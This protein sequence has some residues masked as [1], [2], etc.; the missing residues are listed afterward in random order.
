MDFVVME[1]ISGQ[2]L[3]QV[4]PRRGLPSD[5]WLDYALQMAGA[6]AAAHS[7]GIAHR[8]LKPSNFVMAKSGTIKLFDFGL[9]KPINLRH[10]RQFRSENTN[11]FETAKGTILG[12][13]GYMSPEQVR[14]ESADLRSDI[15]SLGAIFYE[16]LSGRRAFHEKT[17]IDTMSAILHN[18]PPKLPARI[19]APIA[20]IVRRCLEKERSRRYR[21]ATDLATALT[22]AADLAAH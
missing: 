18:A 2:T 14:G 7:Q 15:F 21:T 22:V 10:A 5:V 12:T 17:P 9:A 8:D 13:V 6:L 16:I 3:D 19:P 20:R 11:A 4:T 1:Y